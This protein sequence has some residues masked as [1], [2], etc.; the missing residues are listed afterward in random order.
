[1][2]H[3]VKG[4][5]LNRDVTARRALFKNLTL[6]LIEHGHITTTLAKAQAIKSS[7]DKLVT[8]A[9]QGTLHNRRLID[10]QLN[11]RL[12]VNRL[13]DEIAPQIK[14]ASGFT[15]MTKLG[16]RRGDAAEMVKIEIIDWQPK[17]AAASKA[18]QT[19]KKVA[20]E[21]PTSEKKV[22]SLPHEEKP[23]TKVKLPTTATAAPKH[24]PQKRIAGGK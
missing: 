24:V 22:T 5:Q 2:K 3:A 9:K 17:V 12:A 23:I 15:R 19:T 8:K 13:V 20:K 4:K 6:S 21:E 18:K 10:R 16:M 14:R 11:Q 1:M 7:F